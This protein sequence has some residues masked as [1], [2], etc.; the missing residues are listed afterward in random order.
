MIISEIIST[1][2][3]RIGLCLVSTKSKKKKNPIHLSYFNRVKRNKLWLSSMN[4][5]WVDFFFYFYFYSVFDSALKYT[6]F[7]PF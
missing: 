5:F 2:F 4:V 1:P 3:G 6:I 7:L